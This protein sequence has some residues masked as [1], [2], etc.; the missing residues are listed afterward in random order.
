MIGLELCFVYLIR[1][2]ERTSCSSWS[3]PLRAQSMDNADTKGK[4]AANETR[5]DVP[6]VPL[7]NVSNTYATYQAN[8]RKK[9]T[10]Q[11]RLCNTRFLNAKIVKTKSGHATMSKANN[12]QTAKSCP[13][14]WAIQRLHITAS[15]PMTLLSNLPMGRQRQAMLAIKATRRNNVCFRCN[16]SCAFCEWRY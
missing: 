1:S 3:M 11:M 5:K 15:P 16:I 9:Q 7:L 8:I 13:F 6:S 12:G 14:A 2:A 4:Q 10:R